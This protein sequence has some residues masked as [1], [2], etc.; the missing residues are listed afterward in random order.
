MD[1]ARSG[2]VE[3]ACDF[4]GGGVQER[5]DEVILQ[6]PPTTMPPRKKGI[7][8]KAPATAAEAAKKAEK[9]PT[10]KAAKRAPVPVQQTYRVVCKSRPRAS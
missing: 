4:L 3:D 10:A 9:K 2:G 6:T 7:D 5:R 1:S 8:A